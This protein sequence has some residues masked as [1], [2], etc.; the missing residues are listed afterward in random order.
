M[1]FYWQANHKNSFFLF[2]HK[3][4]L[5]LIAN[6]SFLLSENI[7]SH[8]MAW[9]FSFS[10]LHCSSRLTLVKNSVNYAS[11]VMPIAAVINGES[12]ISPLL[13]HIAP[14]FVLF[15]NNNKTIIALPFVLLN[16]K[17]NRSIFSVLG[18]LFKNLKSFARPLFNLYWFTNICGY[19]NNS[20]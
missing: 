4:I 20:V 14:C 1:N 16:K 18:S 2:F 3:A 7:N 19:Y 5:I 8:K 11:S 17:G 9:Q 13:S 6:I 10:S 12:A 15:N